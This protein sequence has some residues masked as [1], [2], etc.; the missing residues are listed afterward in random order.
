[1]S[2]FGDKA[3]KLRDFNENKGKYLGQALYQYESETGGITNATKEQ[4]KRGL[5]PDGSP[6]SPEYSTEKYVRKKLDNPFHVSGRDPWT[7]NLALTGT[8]YS[9]F[10][11]RLLSEGEQLLT[12]SGDAAWR[13]AGLPQWIAARY[14]QVLG[15]PDQWLNDTLMPI[16]KERLRAKLIELLKS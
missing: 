13:W 14:G 12:E 9:S 2:I 10:T 8:Y 3:A 16:A 1:M 11:L 6:V 15:I 7:P 4:L 5:M